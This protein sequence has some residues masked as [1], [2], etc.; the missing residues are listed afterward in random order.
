MSEGRGGTGL[1]VTSVE[2]ARLDDLD[3]GSENENDCGSFFARFPNG[4]RPREDHGLDSSSEN[5]E[6]EQLAVP[7][8]GSRCTGNSAPD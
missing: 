3:P 4:R 2:P 6:L 8:L 1:R 7:G 5:R